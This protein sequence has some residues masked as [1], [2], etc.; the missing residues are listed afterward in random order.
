VLEAAAE[1]RRKAWLAQ[2]GVAGP[3]AKLRDFMS[4]R[5]EEKERRRQER[6]ALEQSEQ[7]ASAR[8][9]RL[10]LALGALL[11][12][13]A[14]VA[15]VIAVSSGTD[16]ASELPKAPGGVAAQLPPVHETNWS[17]AAKVAGCSLLNPPIEGRDHVS[18]KVHYRTNPPS[19]GNHNI[20]PALDGEYTP[21]NTP[22][23]EHYVHSL[24]HGRIEFEYAPGT[25]SRRVKQL[26][27]LFAENLHGFPGFKTLLFQNNTQM[28]YAVAGV[29]WGHILGCPIFNDKVFD[30]LRAFRLQYV[31]KGPEPNIPPTNVG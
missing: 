20:E 18:A 2:R 24:E 7:R 19:S 22:A 17:T 26:E 21:H 10:Q 23:P 25:P 28:K 11:A 4:S 9:R 30:A 29:A 16:H 13:A 8:Q 15:V 14:V 12:V 1:E 27:T 31:D 5:V 6:L 3:A